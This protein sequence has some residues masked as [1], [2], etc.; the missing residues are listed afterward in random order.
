M[1][2]TNTDQLN[3]SLKQRDSSNSRFALIASLGESIF[4]I[5]DIA[6]IWSISNK[7]TLR[8]TMLR[9]VQSG[10]IKRIYRGLYSL[11][12]AKNIDPYKLGVKAIHSPAYIS[13]ESVLFDKGIINQ[14][15]QEITLVSKFSK[16]F[17]IG[18]NQYRSRQL[19]L[20]FLMNDAGIETVNGIR[21]A[22]TERAIAD[23]YYFNPK[24][25]LDVIN[26]KIVDWKKVKEIIKI[27]GYNVKI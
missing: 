13:C 12:D 22:S 4:H 10:Y 18:N 20:N 23:I 3:T 26:S 16:H 15:S 5:D 8:V 6:N 25:Y 24:K 2:T 1:N 9:Y 14:P 17:N 21:I 11:K 27:V 7:H 19:S